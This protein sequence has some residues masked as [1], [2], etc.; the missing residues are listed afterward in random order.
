[1]A[2]FK[3]KFLAAQQHDPQ[4]DTTAW[5]REIDQLYDLT[6]EEIVI[7]EGKDR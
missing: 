2:I 4:V 7:G 5:E 3:L 1:M 6:P